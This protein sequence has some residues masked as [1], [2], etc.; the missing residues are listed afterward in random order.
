[1]A[2]QELNTTPHVLYGCYVLGR[3][4]F[5]VVLE[6]RQYAVSDAFVSS[7]DDIFQILSTIKEA[8]KLIEEILS[9]IP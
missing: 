2:A 6:G 4:W 9:N 5:F 8:K 3:N 7:Q 1:L